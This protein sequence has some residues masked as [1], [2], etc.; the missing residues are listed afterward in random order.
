M[1]NNKLTKCSVSG[2]AEGAA[3]DFPFLAGET[4][5]QYL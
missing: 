2:C 3:G 4:F 1:S 5:S